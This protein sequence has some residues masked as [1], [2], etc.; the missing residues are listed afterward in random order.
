MIRNQDENLKSS[1]V[2][3][4]LHDSTQLQK[5]VES[6]ADKVDNLLSMHEASVSKYKDFYIDSTE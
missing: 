1:D 2:K 3:M 4:Y 6:V 5:I